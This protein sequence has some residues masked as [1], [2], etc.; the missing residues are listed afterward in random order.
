MKFHCIFFPTS[1]KSNLSIFL[2]F[3]KN[4][5]RS[6]YQVE[7]I[8]HGQSGHGLFLLDNTPGEK[9]S[10]L[11]TIL[12]DVR[13]EEKRKV[14]KLKYPLGNVTSIN[15]TILKGGL[16]VNQVPAE[17]SVSFDLR[18]SANADLDEFEEQVNSW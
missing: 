11:L 7:F 13:A 6:G 14:D 12:Y 18:V 16:Q 10:K 9:L 15:L 1:I 8:I 17:L 3:L 5:Q 2:F 4:R